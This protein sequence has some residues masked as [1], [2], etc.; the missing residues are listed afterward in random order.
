VP[1]VV[2][3][4]QRR[5][6][7]AQAALTVIADKGLAA[8]TM[9]DVAET[10]GC[11]TGMVNHYFENKDELILAAAKAASDYLHR[12]F[13][14]TSLPVSGPD[15]LR[16]QL[17]VGLP[18]HDDVKPSHRV[19]VNLYAAAMHSPELAAH[20]RCFFEE[21]IAKLAA[22]IEAGQRDG[23]IRADLD[24][25]ATAQLLRSAIDSLGIQTLLGMD[26]TSTKELLE[27]LDQLIDQLITEPASTPS[28]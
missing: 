19:I 1:K 25:H 4:E 28:R 17:L 24:P 8:T 26:G 16:E 13:P 27:H 2:D 22:T 21:G 11:S 9:R 20:V 6:E 12:A 5:L 10:A 18:I 7:L 23:W 15:S 3:H 14:A